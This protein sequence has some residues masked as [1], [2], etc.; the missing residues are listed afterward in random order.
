MSSFVETVGRGGGWA[1]EVAIA[2]H[3]AATVN[4]IGKPLRRAPAKLWRAL[5]RLVI[6]CSRFGAKARRTA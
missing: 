3:A 2:A 5:K 1:D 6:D 4:P